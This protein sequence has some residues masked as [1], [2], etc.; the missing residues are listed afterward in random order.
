MGKMRKGDVFLNTMFVMQKIVKG[1]GIITSEFIK[2][3]FLL[4][5]FGYCLEEKELVAVFYFI[6]AYVLPLV[7]KKRIAK[8]I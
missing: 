2:I 1:I 5:A 8:I 4:M 6:F 3:F 7:I